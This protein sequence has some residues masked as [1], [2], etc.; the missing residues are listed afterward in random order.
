MRDRKKVH[1][2]TQILGCGKEGPSETTTA[3]PYLWFCFLQI[4]LP[5]VNHS[6]KLLD[7]KFQK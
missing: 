6:P 5:E 1:K 2:N 7:T 4:Q 3:S